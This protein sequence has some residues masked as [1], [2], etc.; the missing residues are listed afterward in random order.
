MT[1]S[2]RYYKSIKDDRREWRDSMPEVC[3]HCRHRAGHYSTDGGYRW[4]E[5]HE[6]LSRAQAPNAW[7]FRAN[8]LK[9]CQLCHPKVAAMPHAWQLALKKKRDAV[10]YDLDE[11]LRRR[12]PEAMAY[13]TVDE[14]LEQAR[15]IA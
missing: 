15:R 11:W 6:I 10:H 2:E 3:M 4:F 8:Y 9:L 14:V 7:G 1:P 13:V 12:N 5:V